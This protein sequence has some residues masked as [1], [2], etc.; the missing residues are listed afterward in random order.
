MIAIILLIVVLSVLII[1]RKAINPAEITQLREEHT[2]LRIELGKAEERTAYLIEERDKLMS[3][4][5]RER[6][7]LAEVNRLYENNHTYYKIQQEK[8]AEQ[9]SEIEK[10]QEKFSKDFELV[11]A[12]ILDEKTKK[13]TEINRSNMDILLNPLKENIKAFEDKV[14]KVYKSESDER[15]IL[16]GEISKLVELNRQISE[17]AHNLTRA[18]K[19][20]SKKQGN[21]GEIVLDRILEASGL[22]KGESY[23][24]QISYSNDQGERLQ[25][26][27]V[28]NL[29]DNK[30]I[31]V[32]SKVSLIAYERFINC[33][34]EEERSAFTKDHISSI[35]AHIK[36]LCGKNYCDLYGIN[37]PD[38]V[39]L[40]IPV[41]SSFSLAVQHDTDLFEFAWTRR[42][43]IVTPSTLLATLK[44][45]ASIWKQEQQTRNA[46]EIAMKAGAL[47]DKFV[48]FIND[49]KKIGD[50]LDKA[51]D[52]YS[53]AF[54]KLSSGN[55]NLIIRVENLKKLGAK[56]SKNIDERLLTDKLS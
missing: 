41:E 47:Y 10:L 8:I 30:H 18:L 40:F 38:F 34:T 31:V 16:K 27:V 53:E 29:P 26:D 14:E 5:Q 37:T 15:N 54:G 45:I 12:R 17:E 2:N 49:M 33:D 22:V 24:K 6:L 46:I 3:E 48:G 52:S 23:T 39:L 50:S 20:D 25:P 11:A 19:S 51:K 35:K 1:K 4:L 32:D 44:T 13:F 55:G 36:N 28:V 7:E 21:W 43:V 42:V 9:K 56:T